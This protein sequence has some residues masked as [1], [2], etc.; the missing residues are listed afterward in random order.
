MQEPVILLVCPV[1]G[2]AD[3]T[4]D[5][6]KAPLLTVAEVGLARQNLLGVATEVG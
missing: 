5:I 4:A 2:K 6:A 1:L 3:E